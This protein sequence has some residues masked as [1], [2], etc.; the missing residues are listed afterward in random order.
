MKITLKNGPSEL[1]IDT[2]GAKIESLVLDGYKILSVVLRGDS[3][4]GASHPCSPIFGPETETHYGLSQHGPVRNQEWQVVTRTKTELVLTCSV[5]EQNYDFTVTVRQEFGLEPNRL[6]IN[7]EHTNLD[8]RPAPVN[9]AEHFYWNTPKGWDDLR[10]NGQNIGDLP[11][12][13]GMIELK[14]KNKIEIPGLPEIELIQS[15]MPLAVLWAYQNPDSKHYDSHY[16]CLEPAEGPIR[17]NWFGSAASMIGPGH[18]RKTT[19]EISLK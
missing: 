6:R 8:S 16:V 14:E 7:T 10:V 12:E 1:K 15:G 18:S 19:V 17:S 11:K 13:T 2:L 5:T 9:F 4:F 3:K